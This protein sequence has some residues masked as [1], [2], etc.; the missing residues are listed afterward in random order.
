MVT[1]SRLG[2]PGGGGLTQFSC[3]ILVV[4]ELQVQILKL[5]LDNKDDNGVSDPRLCVDPWL[6]G[7][8]FWA[9]SPR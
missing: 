5:L 7:M 8:L 6:G 2:E 3:P 9:P 4:E 1:L